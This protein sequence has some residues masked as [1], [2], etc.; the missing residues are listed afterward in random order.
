MRVERADRLRRSLHCRIVLRDNHLRKYRRHGHAQAGPPE[1]GVDRLLQQVANL[2]LGG[3]VTDIK[4]MPRNLARSS[5]R[6]QEGRADLGTVA[7]SED[8]AVA[9]TDQLGDL[10]RCALCV[11]HLL[12]DGPF[13]ACANQGVPPNRQQYGLH[14]CSCYACTSS[15]IAAGRIRLTDTSFINSSMIAFSACRRFSACWKT[16]ERGESITSSVTTSPR[17]AGRQCMKIASGLA[18]AN[19]AELI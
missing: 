7:V 1:L 17:C 6:A 3:G 11:R 9:V 4:G 16:T 5:F 12:G 14:R 13:F 19:S 18:R 2:T 8:D 15:G 10:R